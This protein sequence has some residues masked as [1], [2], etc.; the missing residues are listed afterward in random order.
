MS[1][2]KIKISRYKPGV[3]DPPAFFTYALTP[4]DDW[5]VLTALEQIRI[6]Q[7]PTLM[8]RRACHHASCGTCACTID[9]VERLACKTPLADLEGPTI[10]LEPLKCFTR[11]GDLVTARN[12][13]F[14]SIQPDWSYLQPAKQLKGRDLLLTGS[15]EAI[16]KF[17]N[18]I[19][20]GCCVAACPVVR[21]NRR[22]YGPAVLANLNIERKKNP[23]AA[24]TLLAQSSASAG[25]PLCQRAL[26]C[27]RVC[28][29]AVYPARH[30]ADLRNQRQKAE[31]G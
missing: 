15:R 29:S 11:V 13:L 20:C 18:C 1:P 14:A 10:T 17:E 4:G 27:S 30:I 22:F 26:S 21:S 5:S 25:E 9:G 3:I 2:V 7:E 31:T 6:H 19:E 8:Y 12:A 23:S 16:M 28:P 24:G